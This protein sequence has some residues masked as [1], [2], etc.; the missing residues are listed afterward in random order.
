LFEVREPLYGV[1][2]LP[3]PLRF[4]FVL[5][6]GGVSAGKGEGRAKDKVG[7]K[8]EG[9]AGGE[10]ETGAGRGGWEKALLME[11]GSSIKK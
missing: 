3:Y 6:L 5:H 2:N 1:L 10:T 11:A 9:V 8:V 7:W 4:F